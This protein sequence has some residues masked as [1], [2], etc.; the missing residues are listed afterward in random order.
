MAGEHELWEMALRVER[1]H[2]AAGPLHIAEMI[3]AAAISGYWDGVAMWKAVAARYDQLE[4]RVGPH[5]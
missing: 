2:G 3:G 5:T 1:E 4:P